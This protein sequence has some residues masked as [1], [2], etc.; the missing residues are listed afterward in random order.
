MIFPFYFLLH[1]FLH[2]QPDACGCSPLIPLSSS[3][4]AE[5]KLEKDF[6]KFVKRKNTIDINEVRSWEKKY[7]PKMNSVSP[8]SSRVKETPE[9]TIYTVTGY[10]YDV[11]LKKN[12]C[13]LHLEIGT[14]NVN[15]LRIVAEIPHENCKLQQKLLDELAKKNFLYKHQN[16]K[17]IKCTITGLGFYD[18]NHP[19]KENKKHE[20]GNSWEIH[21]VISIELN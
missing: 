20:R 10:I 3:Y 8:V 6:S 15:D 18:G 16:E 7:T 13:D 1:L 11:R 19:E 4:R 5:A 12:D 2:F 21:P 14:E 17:G 9:D